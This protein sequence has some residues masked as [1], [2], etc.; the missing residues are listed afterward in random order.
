MSP[1]VIEFVGQPGAGKTTLARSLAD[2]LRAEG[3]AVAEPTD[4]LANETGRRRRYAT[5]IVATLRQA[6]SHP[7]F[8]ATSLRATGRPSLADPW[9]WLRGLTNWQYVAEEVRRAGARDTERITVLDQGVAQ[10]LW[11]VGF[12][13]R[14]GD[15]EAFE[16]LLAD[17]YAGPEQ[18][19]VVTVRADDATIRRRLRKRDGPLD[20]PFAPATMSADVARG[21]NLLDSVLDVV[22][23]VADDHGIKTITVENGEDEAL[24]LKTAT[25]L[26]GLDH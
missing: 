15:L 16:P 12:M 25:I 7:G 10:A 24:D 5:K 4:R 3:R 19:V 20:H 23:R 11:S 14:P 9:G 22:D 2:E 18:Y 26:R 8:T 1:A 21:R 17:L 13:A 6:A